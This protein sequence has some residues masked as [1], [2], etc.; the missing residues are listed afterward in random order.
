MCRLPLKGLLVV[1]GCL[2]IPGMAAAQSAI[3][4][5]VR[6]STGAV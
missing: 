4:G 2:A 6:D 1:V 3:A 5:V